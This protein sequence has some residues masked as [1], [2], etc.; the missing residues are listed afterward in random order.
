MNTRILGHECAQLY[1]SHYELNVPENSRYVLFSKRKAP[2]TEIAK[3]LG[4]L[5]SELI[6]LLAHDSLFRS[7]LF[8]SLAFSAS[9]VSDL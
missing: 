4:G 3:G 5:S 9:Q 7:E 6:M 8:Q 2:A 1:P